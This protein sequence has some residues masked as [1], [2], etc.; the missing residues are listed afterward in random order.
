MNLFPTSKVKH[1][2]FTSSNHCP[3]LLSLNLSQVRNAPPFC[4]NKQWTSRDDF[5]CIVKKS[6]RCRFQG[7]H[8][9]C[10][11][12]KCKLLKE[13]AKVWSTTRFGNI[14]RQLRVVEEESK[15]IQER[16]IVESDSQYLNINLFIVKKIS[17]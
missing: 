17:F 2:N 15:S 11:T 6:C 9:F 10:F 4:F 1:H 7:S 5:D 14:F 16:L 8:L 12:C 3:I 13:K